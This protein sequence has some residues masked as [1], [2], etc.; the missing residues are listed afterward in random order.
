MVPADLV[1]PVRQHQHRR[2]RG[3]PPD[4]VP[5][6]VQGGFVGPVHVLDHQNGRV[7]G[8]A[9]LRTQRVQQPVA[10]PTSVQRPV[11]LGADAADQIA[12]RAQGPAGGQ[13]VAVSDEQPALRRQRRP[14]RL[15]QAGLTD[16]GLAADKHD[17]AGAG[18]CLPRGGGQLGQLVLALQHQPAHPRMVAR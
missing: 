5:Q 14:E 13:V 10:V 1:V 3:D 2:Q 7:P 17:R 9:Q 4:E 18:R 16:P 15:D 8:P 6:D 12:E 11:Q